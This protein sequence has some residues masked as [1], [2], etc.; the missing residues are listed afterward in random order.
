[1]QDDL[2][3]LK[4]VYEPFLASF[5]L[6]YGYWKKYAEVEARHQSVATALEIYE[7]GTTATPYSMDLWGAYASYKKANEG[8]A[9]E[10]RG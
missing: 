6:S 5:P 7:R 10:V 1:M 4:A 9:E 2:E 8:T 3:R